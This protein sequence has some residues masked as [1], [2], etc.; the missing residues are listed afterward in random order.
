MS[1]TVMPQRMS[2]TRSQLQEIRAELERENRRF[3]PDDARAEAF[4]A[5]LD[6]IERGTYGTCATC[7]DGISHERLSVMPETVYCVSCRRGNS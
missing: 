5:A 4:A 3:A 6:R 7:G 1:S 2:L